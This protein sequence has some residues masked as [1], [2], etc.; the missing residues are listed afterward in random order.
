MFFLPYTPQQIVTDIADFEGMPVT[1]AVTV[2]THTLYSDWAQ[3]TLPWDAT[4]VDLKANVELYLKAC[5]MPELDRP[6]SLTDRFSVYAGNEG[7]LSLVYRGSDE[8]QYNQTVSELLDDHKTK[9]QRV[10]VCC[11]LEFLG[12]TTHLTDAATS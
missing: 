6:V 1:F 8:V 7:K 2:Q 9:Y 10:F 11:D 5:T 12:T 3:D 4:E